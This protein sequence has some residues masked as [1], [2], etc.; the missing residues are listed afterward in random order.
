[1]G[2]TIYHLCK[3]RGFHWISRA[4][5]KQAEADSKGEGGKVKKGLAETKRRIAEKRYRSAAE[6]VLAEFP[7][8][9]AQRNKQGD[10]G[11]ALSRILLADELALLF[12]ATARTRCNP[13]AEAQLEAAIL[14]SGDRKSGL[15]WE[16]KPPL[17]GQRPAQRCSANALSR[18]STEYR[19]PKASFTAERHV[20][21]TRLN[22]LRIVVDGV[23]RGSTRRNA[24]PPCRSPTSRRGFHLQA[25][26]CRTGQGWSAAGFLQVRRPCLSHRRTAGRGSKPK[27]RKPRS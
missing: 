19:A 16:Q 26:A 23:T 11:K 27:T 20:W 3:H 6:M 12:Q 25:V 10:Y 4:E 8:P 18:S 24:G 22:N 13:H 5:E 9:E 2:A 1:M 17:A 15:F 21:L 7:P 14:G